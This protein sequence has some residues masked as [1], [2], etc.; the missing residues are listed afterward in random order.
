MLY[1]MIQLQQI[2]EGFSDKSYLFYCFEAMKELHK[3]LD[4]V[5]FHVEDMDDDDIQVYERNFIISLTTMLSKKG[6]TLPGL[7]NGEVAKSLDAFAPTEI[8]DKYITLKRSQKQDYAPKSCYV[9]PDFLIHES[10]SLDKAS[11]NTKNQHIIIEA[12][13]NDITNKNAFFLDLFKLNAYLSYLHFENAIYLIVQT[14]ISK[15][16]N[17]LLEYRN[18]VNFFSDSINNLYFFI[19]EK[20]DDEPKIYKIKKD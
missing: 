16:N 14:S 3:S 18:Q 13:T 6:F 20:I 9:F 4:W 19:Q 5:C 17:Y 11:W 2:N 1:T 7:I 8:R 15:I 12:K 10:H